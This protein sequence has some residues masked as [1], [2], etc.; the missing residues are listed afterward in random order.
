MKKTEEVVY[1]LRRMQDDVGRCFYMPDENTVLYLADVSGTS[2]CSLIESGRI[3]EDAKEIAENVT[4]IKGAT[5]HDIKT[6]E[7]SRSIIKALTQNIKT[8]KDIKDRQ[9][10]LIKNQLELTVESVIDDLLGCTERQ[11]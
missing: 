9:D 4:P 1:F 2:S 6:F 8:L 10:S 3:L 11:N 5:F 7:Y